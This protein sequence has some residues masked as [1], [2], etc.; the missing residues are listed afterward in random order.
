[1]RPGRRWRRSLCCR[2]RACVGSADRHRPSARRP[3]SAS[4]RTRRRLPSAVRPPRPLVLRGRPVRPPTP[5]EQV[6]IDP[7]RRRPRSSSDS[8]S[9]PGWR[10]SRSSRRRSRSLPDGSIWILDDVKQRVAHY[11]GGRRVPRAGRRLRVRSDPPR[12]RRTWP[13]RRPAVRGRAAG[14]STRSGRSGFVDGDATRVGRGSR[15]LGEWR[16]APGLQLFRAPPELDRR[17]GGGSRDA[18]ATD[19]RAAPTGRRHG[20]TRRGRRSRCV[21]PGLRWAPSVGRT[22]R[23]RRRPGLRRH[24]SSRR[25]AGSCQPIHVRGRHLRPSPDRWTSGR[26]RAGHG[27]GVPHGVVVFV[28]VLP[29]ATRDAD[30][31]GGGRVVPR[32][33]SDDGAA[34]LGAAARYGYHRHERQARHLAG[35]P[36]GP[37]T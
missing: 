36:T 17:L 15:L 29:G 25:D 30:R 32:L 2:L 20:S 8:S 9:T 21:G 28:R 35:G 12:A 7:V 34:R 27:G 19:L 10:R 3:P 5:W 13:S 33:G 37:S 23:P 14:E 1:M 22:W 31:Y 4:R 6:A 18:P 24:R 11:S 16:P 26:G